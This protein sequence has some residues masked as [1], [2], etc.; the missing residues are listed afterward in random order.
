MNTPQ[1]ETILLNH[2]LK[3]IQWLT[4]NAGFPPWRYEGSSHGLYG[5]Q[6]GTGGDF[7][8]QVF[9]FTVLIIS[10]SIF[11]T[12]HYSW[13]MKYGLCL[14]ILRKTMKEPIMIA[15][16]LTKS[17]TGH[18]LNTSLEC[19]HYDSLPSKWLSKITLSSHNLARK[20]RWI[21]GKVICD[22]RVIILKA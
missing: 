17:W 16:N 2:N 3:E 20:I 1:S 15:G 7:L 6:S 10:P 4:F 11:N 5:E 22:G 9:S 21:R 12:Y 14:E 19:Y 8:L 18:H 13:G